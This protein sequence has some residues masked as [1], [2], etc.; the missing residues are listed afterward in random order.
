MDQQL[1]LWLAPPII[2]GIAYIYF[3][4]KIPLAWSWGFFL[5]GFLLIG[6]GACGYLVG[7]EWFYVALSWTLFGLFLIAPKVLIFSC[8]QYI[9]LLDSDKLFFYSRFFPLIYWGKMGLFWR[10]LYLANAYAIAGNVAR[11]KEILN[12]W[13]NEFLPPI[14]DVQLNATGTGIN[15]IARDWDG[16]IQEYEERLSKNTPVS[17]ALAV[18][19]A[20]AFSE[21]HNFER[22]AQCFESS[23]LAETKTDPTMLAFVLL[24]FFCLSGQKVYAEKLLVVLHT[25]K[26]KT[27]EFLLLYWQARLQ[28][29]LGNI[30][31]ARHLFAQSLD[32][33]KQLSVKGQSN[34]NVWQSRIEQQLEHLDDKFDLPEPDVLHKIAARVWRLFTDTDFVSSAVVPTKAAPT[35]IMLCGILCLAY[36]MSGCVDMVTSSWALPLLNLNVAVGNG[37]VSL[38]EKLGTFCFDNGT[39]DR[40]TFWNDGQYFRLFTYMFLHGNITHLFLN[41]VAVYWF[42][43]RAASIFSAKSF[44]FIFVFTGII[45]G[46]THILF[47]A[48]PVIGASGGV[49]GV[50]GADFAGI[51]RL[52]NR[53]PQRV[54]KAELT[55]MSV[56][57]VSQL[58]LDHVI[59]KVSGETHMGGLLAGLFVGFLL[60]LSREKEPRSMKN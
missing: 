4:L 18:Q 39:L 58:V 47:S 6:A 25:A 16:V 34:F 26:R 42:G 8:D 22:A 56:L 24:P 43:K 31:D 55:S 54:R 49:L 48:I 13:R 12:N 5:Q 57:A 52:K 23:R 37:I 20:R 36:V 15:L 21:K 41:V 2:M 32:S 51:F 38:S 50:F 3:R 1:K 29:T 19:A 45:G 30:D 59:P 28:V 60:P 9:S 35:V 17:V 44:L 14:V 7:P 46:L 33:A 10:D 53:L 40:E 11:G 27:A